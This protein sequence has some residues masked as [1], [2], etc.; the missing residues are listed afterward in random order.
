M[1]AADEVN[2]AAQIAERFHHAYEHLAPSFGYETRKQSSVPW[3]QVPEPNRS[4]MVAVVQDLLDRDVIRPGSR[5]GDE[6]IA[7]G[8]T[9]R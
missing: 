8:G 4:L 3:E 7:G 5:N 2:D 9:D 6:P 1:A